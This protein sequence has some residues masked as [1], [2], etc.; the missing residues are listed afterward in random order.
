SGPTIVLDQFGYRTKDEKIAVIRSP[1]KGF[2]A[3]PAF[4]PGP[5]YALVRASGEPTKVFEAAPRPWRDGMVDPS[6]G[7]R[8]WWF[9]FSS[10]TAPGDYFVLDEAKDVRSDAF[11]IADDVYRDVLTQAMRMF[12]YQRDGVSKDAKYAGADWADGPA[13]MGPGQDP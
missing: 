7:D 4:T 3:G 5:R 2:D 8:A 13:H 9:D 6:S 11:R 10:V 1:V 12:Y